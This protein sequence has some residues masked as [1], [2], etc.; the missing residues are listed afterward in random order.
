MMLKYAGESVINAFRE[1]SEDLK[2]AINSLMTQIWIWLNDASI[3]VPGPPKEDGSITK[4]H[5]SPLQNVLG[6]MIDDV[7]N[8][9]SRKLFGQAGGRTKE[10]NEAM[11]SMGIPLPRK[12]Q[13]TQEFLMEQLAQRVMPKIE[14]VVN[15]KL[16]NMSKGS[17]DSGQ[18]GW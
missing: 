3:E 9:M 12:G 10:A 7:V 2:T 15:S 1:P 5:I 6:A 17:K 18:K 14:E 13:T 4:V 16:E 8:R 11:R